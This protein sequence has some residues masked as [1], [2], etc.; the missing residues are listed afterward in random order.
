MTF[1]AYAGFGVPADAVPGGTGQL[2]VIVQQDFR[3]W[4]CPGSLI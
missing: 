3:R 4:I 2:P 1:A